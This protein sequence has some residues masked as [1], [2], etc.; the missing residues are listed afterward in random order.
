MALLRDPYRIVHKFAVHALQRI[1][2]PEE[3]KPIAKTA[4]LNLLGCYIRDRQDD[5]FFVD[6]LAFYLAS[7]ATPEERA[8]T[9]GSWAI[10]SLEKIEP[11]YVADEVRSLR[12]SLREHDRYVE[13]LIRLA[14]DARAWNIYHDE[15]TRALSD[16]P[17]QS[18]Y[19][20]RQAL[21]ALAA[22]AQAENRHMDGSFIELFTRAG[23]WDEAAKLARTRVAGLP[24]DA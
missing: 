22:T 21:A 9:L 18:A 24:D 20:H 15:L 4:V 11:W 7:Y 14:G 5:R 6:T 2:L 17:A 19:A 10:A 1:H 23:A 12:R 13:L 8:G 3:F 16:L